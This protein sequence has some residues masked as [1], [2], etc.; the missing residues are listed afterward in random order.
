MYS[1]NRLTKEEKLLR[2]GHHWLYQ[3]G[4]AGNRT[5]CDNEF[6]LNAASGRI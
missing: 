4:H 6:K 2:P 3:F 5:S 1:M